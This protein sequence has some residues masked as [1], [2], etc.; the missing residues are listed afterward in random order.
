[1]PDDPTN[2][3]R[4]R[5]TST[6]GKF[7]WYE[8]MTTDTAAAEAFYRSVIGWSAKDAG[9]PGI[10]YTFLTVGGGGV[11]GLMALPE[12]AR[13]AAAGPGWMGYVAVD[14]KSTRLNSSHS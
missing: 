13:D 11:A 7:V 2:G 4:K 10:A 12:G 9:V 5:I 6:H 14:R 3:G 8:L 1:M